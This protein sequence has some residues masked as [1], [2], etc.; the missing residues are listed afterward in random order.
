MPLAV[1]H[2]IRTHSAS[3]L[4]IVLGITDKQQLCLRMLLAPSKG[5][6]HLATRVDIIKSANLV[7]IPLQSKVAQL[8]LEHCDLGCGEQNL[9]ISHFA[10][11]AAFAWNWE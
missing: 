8:P 11:A 2:A 3:N 4:V 9:R 7:E 6:M 1:Q 5:S 10:K